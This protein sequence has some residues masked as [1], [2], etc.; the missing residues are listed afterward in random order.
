MNKSSAWSRGYPVDQPYPVAWHGIQ[1]PAWLRAVCAVNGVVW[2]VD[3]RTP[4]S[5]CELGCG[6][7]YTANVL[8]AGNPH[9][10]VFGFDYNPAHIAEARQLALGAGLDNA[11]FLELD[12]AELDGA[13]LATLPEFDL[14]M[15]HGVW[16]WV[17]DPV[18]E[19][20]LRLLRS[21]LKAGGLALVTYNALPGA[22]SSLG[23]SRL[24]QPFLQDSASSEQAVADA[25]T[26]VQRLMAANVRHIGQ[27][28]WLGMLAGEE[29]NVD[30][31]YLRHEFATTHWRPAFF[32]DVAA[33][34]GS[35]R[36][37]YVGSATIDENFPAL[38]LTPDQQAIWREARD[39]A[40]RELVFDLCVPRA[41]RRDLYVRGVR[42][43]NRVNATEAI[44]IALRDGRDGPLILRSQAGE[45]QLPDALVQAVRTRLRQGAATIGMLKTLPECANATAEELLATLL[46]SR[47]AVPLWQGPPAGRAEPALQ[48]RLIRFNRA[49]AA[50][51]APHGVGRNPLALPLPL[52][53]G[54][55]PVGPLE[56]AVR[57]TLDSLDAEAAG[58][59]VHP[60]PA[61]SADQVLRHL[62]PPGGMPPPDVL[63]ELR[64]AIGTILTRD[65]PIWRA[66]GT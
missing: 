49:S 64:E 39:L 36:C 58:G 32:A 62:L 20:V 43:I 46:G 5:I 10:Q 60:A 56:L 17:D 47:F 1:S 21:R 55:L 42:R 35:A 26:L 34:F 50:R 19:G 37:D 65:V 45:A 4:L 52:Q 8:A 57:V 2:D 54:A 24:V 48:A 22:A 63:D 40:S 44:W 33:A 30:A 7:G 41:F 15:L 18:R 25:G 6:T 59:G 66:V 23:L 31:G 13:A 28:R 12:V 38:S 61:A 9:W 11:H 53:G 27:S 14:V 51:F 3:E 29:K 16:S